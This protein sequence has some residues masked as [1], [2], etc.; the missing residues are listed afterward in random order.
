MRDKIEFVFAITISLVVLIAVTSPL[1][2]GRPISD[3]KA[4]ILETVILAILL[5]LSRGK[6]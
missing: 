3:S 5:Y 1:I 6:R 2:T 4:K